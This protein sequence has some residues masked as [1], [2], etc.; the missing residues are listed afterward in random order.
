[1]ALPLLAPPLRLCSDNAVMAGFAGLL[2]L[3]TRPWDRAG[4]APRWRWP[5]N[6]VA[7]P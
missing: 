4:H 5:S 1:M 6:E 2:R 3:A 7:A